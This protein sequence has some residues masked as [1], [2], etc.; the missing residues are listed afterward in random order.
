MLRTIRVLPVSCA[1]ACLVLAPWTQAFAAERHDAP[2]APA[3]AV[4]APAPPALTVSGVGLSSIA[5]GKLPADPLFSLAPRPSFLAAQ[6]RQSVA[7]TNEPKLLLGIAAGA[8]IVTGV[9]LI[10]YGA[11]STCNGPE[12]TS[13]SCD[14]KKMLG[15]M[16]VSGGTMMLVLW[17]LSRP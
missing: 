11:S 16:T 15:A 10:T 3:P 4:P 7:T 17:A 2:P 6:K 14:K 5:F 13:S 9:T 12:G 1:L 8:L